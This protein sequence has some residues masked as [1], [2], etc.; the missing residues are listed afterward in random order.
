MTRRREAAK[1]CLLSH[2]S[3][4]WHILVGIF[5]KDSTQHMA[6]A[7]IALLYTFALVSYV[8]GCAARAQT[9]GVYALLK[10]LKGS[11]HQQSLLLFPDKTLQESWART[12]GPQ[13]VLP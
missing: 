6:R 4:G 10:L 12:P 13:A 3:V 5:V 7:S 9:E 1:Q 11:Q 8:D 2:A